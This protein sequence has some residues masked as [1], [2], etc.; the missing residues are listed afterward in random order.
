[1]SQFSYSDEALVP[2]CD[3]LFTP[4]DLDLLTAGAFGKPVYAMARESRRR[5]ALRAC[6]ERHPDEHGMETPAVA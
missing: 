2:F 4:G 5:Q 1:M 6:R 3:V